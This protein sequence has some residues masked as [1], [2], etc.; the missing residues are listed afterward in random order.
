MTANPTSGA[1]PTPREFQ[2]RR[3]GLW[4][5]HRHSGQE[6]RPGDTIH[7]PRMQKLTFIKFEVTET[8]NVYVH[9]QH[10]ERGIV[11]LAPSDVLRTAWHE[12]YDT[13]TIAL[14]IEA[15]ANHLETY[16]WRCTAYR[17]GWNSAQQQKEST[18]P[19][20]QRSCHMD[21]ALSIVVHGGSIEMWDRWDHSGMALIDGTARVMED[22]LQCQLE[23]YEDKSSRTAEDVISFMRTVAGWIRAGWLPFPNEYFAN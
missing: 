22:Y 10:P 13:G 16:G 14:V 7:G 4:L 18:L 6:V 9:T 19:R 5:T 23:E 3:T 2:E 15:A 11:E 20:E 21:E 8:G 17:Y 12:P 1:Y